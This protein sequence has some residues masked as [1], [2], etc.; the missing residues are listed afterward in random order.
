MPDRKAVTVNERRRA[1]KSQPTKNGKI[2]FRLYISPGDTSSSRALANLKTICREHFGGNYE[3]EIVD[4]LKDPQRAKRDGITGTPTLIKRS[5]APVWT[6]AG[7]L[8]EEA[9]ILAEMK[10]KRAGRRTR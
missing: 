6:I 7:D 8:S 3:I 2:A 4:T 10:R 1:T 5:P 9:L